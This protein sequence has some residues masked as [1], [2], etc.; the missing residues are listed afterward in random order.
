MDQVIMQILYGTRFES[1]GPMRF[2]QLAAQTFLAGGSPGV[3][4][5]AILEIAG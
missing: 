2:F 3:R 5:V 4:K 1:R